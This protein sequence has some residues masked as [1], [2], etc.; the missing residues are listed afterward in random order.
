[1]LVML[2]YQFKEA[3]SR[4]ESYLLVSSLLSIDNERK[5]FDESEELAKSFSGIH[6]LFADS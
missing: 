5:D 6:T 3:G 4:I 2:I 1:M